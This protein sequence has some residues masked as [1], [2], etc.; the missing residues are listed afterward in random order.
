MPSLFTSQTP[1]ATNE[2]DGAPGIVTATTV[3]F[4]QAGNITHV[5]FYATTTVGGTYSVGVWEV[6]A[7]DSD[8]PGAGTLLQSTAA[9]TPTSGT[10]NTVELPAPVPVVSGKLYR[11]G[12][13]NNQGRYVVTGG[14][15]TTDLVN[16]DITADQT[17]DDPVG[18]G[19]MY[20]GSYV[21]AGSLSYPTESFNA[22]NYFVD[23][24]YQVGGST[25][26]FTKN[27]STVWNVRNTFTKNT[28][29]AWH[30]RNAFSKDVS[31]AWHVRNSISKFIASRWNV[32]NSWQKDAA[33]EWRVYN[34]FN[35]YIASRWNVRELWS[36]DHPISWHIQG[37][38]S[39]DQP[40]QWHVRALLTKDVASAWNILADTSWSRAFPTRWHVLAPW[41]TGVVTRWRILS[42]TPP[43][44]LPADVQVDLE[45]YVECILAPDSVTVRLP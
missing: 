24:V 31:S 25:T 9:P 40:M 26:P 14:F 28:A 38:W 16:G 19:T 21:V 32:R 35:K 13:F 8:A 41:T 6:T 3:R 27:V 36:T 39:V 4:A 33:T 2:S 15:F 7:P 10:W 12:L 1:S 18:L 5:R 37:L 29:S 43:P 42:D 34:T 30:V 45:E 44:P 11:V 17:S 20:Q 23:V 22:S